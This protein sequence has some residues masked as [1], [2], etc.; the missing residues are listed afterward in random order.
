MNCTRSHSENVAEW[1]LNL[2]LSDISP[3]PCSCVITSGQHTLVEWCNGPFCITIRTFHTYRHLPQLSLASSIPA[4]LIAMHPSSP[5]RLPLTCGCVQK[6]VEPGAIQ[7][8]Q[9]GQGIA[10]NGYSIWSPQ[11]LVLG[12]KEVSCLIDT[13]LQAL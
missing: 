7:L 9:L 12:F 2:N 11:V 5:I 1:D 8:V 6:F 13:A 10:S 4:Q 3:W